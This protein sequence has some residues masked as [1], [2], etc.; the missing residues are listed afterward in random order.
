MKNIY[1]QQLISTDNAEEEYLNLI[2]LCRELSITYATGHNWLKLGKITRT[3]NGFSRSYVEQLKKSL[4]ENDSVLKTRRNKR[5]TGGQKLYVAYLPKYSANI[6]PVANISNCIINN[7][8][9]ITEDLLRTILVSAAITM[10]RQQNSP[11]ITDA[12]KAAENS[13]EPLLK[14]VLERRVSLGKFTKLLEPLLPHNIAQALIDTDN[15]PELFSQK[16]VHENSSDT[17]GFLYI[18]CSNMG[19]RKAHGIYYTPTD[20]VMKAV[21]SITETEDYRNRT[22]IDPCCGTG[23]FL[24][25]LPDDIPFNSIY[26][27]DID[28]TAI[29]LA[30]ISMGL[31][32]PEVSAEMLESHLVVSNYLTSIFKIGEFDCIIGNPPWGSIFSDEE[33]E[34][35][36]DNFICAQKCRHP[37]SFELFIE[38][39]V[40][41]LKP[42][43]TLTFVVPE[44]LLNVKSH[45][46]ARELIMKETNITG[47]EYLGDVF[48]GVQ[49]PAII[50]RLK[51]TAK[52]FNTRGLVI[53]TPKRKFTISKKRPVRAENF[54]FN[55]TD[56][57]Y[58]IIS[59]MNRNGKLSLKDNAAFAMGIV[60]GS[61]RELLSSAPRSERSECIICGTDIRKYGYT[62]GL[63]FIEFTPEKF[64]QCADEACYRAPEKLIYRFINKRLIFAYDN[65]QVLTLNSANILIPEL[66]ELDIFCVLAVLNSRPAQFYFSQNFNSCKVLR[67]HLEAFPF[68]E[69]SHEEQAVIK[70]M[71]LKLTDA[72]NLRQDSTTYLEKQVVD[73]TENTDREAVYNE[74]DR[75]IA[76]VYGLT[77]KQYGVILESTAGD[78]PL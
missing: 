63:N 72:Q 25:Q 28:A 37:E 23:N 50:L 71:A 22:F 66:S 70:Q 1:P 27:N 15:H 55:L 17:L 52:G 26:G 47:I 57:E 3:E 62:T 16:F 59:R 12:V 40:R 67:S 21:A 7:E 45:Q 41:E 29:M 53:K 4:R 18:S 68:P 65:R 19:Q 5:L 34:F 49:C 60:T 8:I 35:I 9:E 30:R 46:N 69:I 11:E 24:M 73:G 6:E 14:A 10:I 42:D 54:S 20:I 76:A 31:K 2:Q 51:K 48:D 78:G 74:L 56:T 61:N 32:Y 39:A 43:G 33:E 77:G 36:R 44:S 64:Q 38:E 75:R 58:E 13:G